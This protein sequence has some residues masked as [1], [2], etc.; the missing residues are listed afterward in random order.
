MTPPRLLVLAALA[1]TACSDPAPAPAPAP[2]VAVAP[3]PRDPVPPGHVWP[4]TIAD[5]TCAVTLVARV[6]ARGRALTD[7]A[8]EAAL[9]DAFAERLFGHPRAP[10]RRADPA[11]LRRA[12]ELREVSAGTP[13]TVAMQRIAAAAGTDYALG[14]AVSALEVA[15]RGGPGREAITATVAAELG[16]DPKRAARAPLEVVVTT[17]GEVPVTASGLA[18]AR[19]ALLVELGRRLA[20][21]LLERL[22]ALSPSAALARQEVSVVFKRF[23]RA[24][25]AELV[26]LTRDAL[27]ELTD[28][29]AP[30]RE[31]SV[32]G[33]ADLLLIAS[34]RATP[35]A[36][37]EA[38]RGALSDA[39]VR[40]EVVV[41]ADVRTVIV[42][43]R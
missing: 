1:L 17:S 27:A 23:E 39:G 11:A 6:D 20:D 22:V 7:P 9:E 36:L 16:T 42:T 30:L 3:A 5:A 31:S 33:A 18:E 38:L 4:V 28:R 34:T 25:A 2:A 37:G 10:F 35:S 12:A 32:E 15:S 24:F 14:L 8:E 19:R 43:A 21:A 41:S 13:I 26:A 40:A 29:E